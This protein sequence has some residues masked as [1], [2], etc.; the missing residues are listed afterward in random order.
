MTLRHLKLFIEVAD[1]GKMSLA[2]AKY[3]ISQPTVSQAIKELE[4]YYN[5]LL[6]ERLSKKLYI[7]QDGKKLLQ[8][9]RAVVQSFDELEERMFDQKHTHTLR[10]GSTITVA[11]SLI[12][13]IAASMA[14]KSPET[15]VNV[16]TDNTRGIER[17]ILKSELDIA[18]VEGEAKSTDI[19]AIPCVEDFLVLVCS[20]KHRFTKMDIIPI[21]ELVNENFIVR[22]EGSGTRELFESTMSQMKS[23]ITIGWECSTPEVMKKAVENNLGVSVMSVRLV[24][25]EIR[26][27]KLCAR[28]VEGCD[29][30]R[31]FSII[32][33][34]DKYITDSMR[35]IIELIRLTDTLE[36]VKS[37]IKLV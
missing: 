34:K 36:D 5:V 20:P 22:E 32:Y 3:F 35:T 7:T 4:E 11:N 28:L 8:Y 12:T 27:Q 26:N 9:A 21:E 25:E 19:V 24:R 1:T 16:Y 37:L 13:D 33:H 2:A 29:W 14:T 10:I 18:L 30:S 15:H 23:R 31:Q 6:F 17:R